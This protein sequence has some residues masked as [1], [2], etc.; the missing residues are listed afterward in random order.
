MSNLA[1]N[2]SQ[3][4]SIFTSEYNDVDTFANGKLADIINWATG[5]AALVAV[6][7]L[8]IAGYTYITSAGDA[9]KVEK[10][11]KTIT[12]SIVGLVIVLI[13]RIL[14]ELVLEKIME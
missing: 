3:F 14:V 11:G 7:F 1:I 5:F 9:D 12:A 8:I 10:A 13:A 2:I 4:S 6:V